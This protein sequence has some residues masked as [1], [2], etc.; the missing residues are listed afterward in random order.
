MQHALCVRVVAPVVDGGQRLLDSRVVGVGRAVQQ[1]G[2]RLHRIEAGLGVQFDAL[3]L[4]LELRRLDHLAVDADPAAGDV[5]VGLAPRTAE[6]FDDAFG[7]ADGFAHAGWLGWQ[8]GGHCNA[9]P[10]GMRG[11]SADEF[12]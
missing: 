10:V 6:Q 7:Q 4:D 5:Q 2:H 12:G 8:K 11:Y 3:A 1:Q 9:P